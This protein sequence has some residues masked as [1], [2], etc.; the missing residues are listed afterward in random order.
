M[1][2]VK[3]DPLFAL[4]LDR[5]S[6][7]VSTPLIVSGMSPVSGGGVV[8]TTGSQMTAQAQG[9]PHLDDPGVSIQDA[10]L[11]AQV[12]KKGRFAIRT[13]IDNIAAR[14][15]NQESADHQLPTNHVD[16]SEVCIAPLM[17]AQHRFLCFYFDFARF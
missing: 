12:K 3:D 9:E 6:S 5:A 13:V 11:E 8:F 4:Q 17:A 16:S 14:S 1:N 2:L 7:D 15:Q 10:S